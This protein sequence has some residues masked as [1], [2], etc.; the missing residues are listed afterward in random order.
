VG[1]DGRGEG[2][3]RIAHIVEVLGSGRR[4]AER[5]GVMPCRPGWP[6][7]GRARGQLSSAPA[8]EAL[9]AAAR[10]IEPH[11]HGRMVALDGCTRPPTCIAHPLDVRLRHQ[12]E[13]VLVAEAGA[14]VEPRR[15]PLLL[16]ERRATHR[17][18]S[19]ISSSAFPS[20]FCRSSEDDDI[21]YLRFSIFRDVPYNSKRRRPATTRAAATFFAT[22]GDI[23]IWAFRFPWKVIVRALEARS[24]LHFD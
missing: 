8:V 9:Q 20:A 1:G 24:Q 17:S 3:S 2:C 18:C 23:G 14:R 6:C 15:V 11:P 4:I 16:E 19:T 22:Y 13:V 5:R 7:R 10:H 12:P 21:S